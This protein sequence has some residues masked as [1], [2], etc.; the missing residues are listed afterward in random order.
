MKGIDL[1]DGR[2]SVEFPYDEAQPTRWQHYANLLLAIDSKAKAAKRV[3]ATLVEPADSEMK[4]FC[5]GFLLQLGLGG[6]QY[7]ELRSVLLG[8]L[9]G[10]AAFRTGKRWMRT[11]RSTQ[12]CAGRCGKRIRKHKA[13]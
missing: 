11:G 13:R 1:D 3:N 4:Y 5:R 7:K 6:P 10:F 12:T 9:H 2:L 8:H